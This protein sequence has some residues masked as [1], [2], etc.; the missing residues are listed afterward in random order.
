[1]KKLFLFSILIGV[2]LSFAGCGASNANVV[3]QQKQKA[4]E[5]DDL[6]YEEFKA[7]KAQQRLN[8]EVQ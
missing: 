6:L 7:K 1:M 4:V 5:D 3:Q 2:F 8:Q